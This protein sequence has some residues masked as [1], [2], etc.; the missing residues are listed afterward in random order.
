M[1]NNGPHWTDKLSPASPVKTNQQHAVLL[2]D[3][4]ELQASSI[5]LDDAALRMTSVAQEFNNLLT[6][7]IGYS[8][9]LQRNINNNLEVTSANELLAD[10]RSAGGRAKALTQD[11]FELSHVM[12]SASNSFRILYVETDST[13]RNATELGLKSCGY[14]VESFSTHCE[15]LQFIERYGWNFDIVVCVVNGEQA[16]LVDHMGTCAILDGNSLIRAIEKF[17]KATVPAVYVC[18]AEHATQSNN[19]ADV[20]LQKPYKYGEFLECVQHTLRRANRRV[21]VATN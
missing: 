10:I 15:A 18:D 16:A 4:V 17:S 12:G 14:S 7:I 6:V 5:D 20:V 3:T 19:S 1:T 9:L 11:L 2:K 8:E 13:V 21:S